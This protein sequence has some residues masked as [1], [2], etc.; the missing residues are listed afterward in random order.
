[1]TCTPPTEQP[2]T[3]EEAAARAICWADHALSLQ[4]RP[5]LDVIWWLSTH[6]VASDRVLHRSLRKQPE[7]RAAVRAQ[8]GRAR[9]IHATL[10]AL[11][12]HLTGDGRL[13]GRDSRR[14]A[15]D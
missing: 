13:G 8:R 4:G 7:Y 2:E 14:L 5:M 11:D 12:R 1:M 10:W 3:I 6:L 15:E 9:E